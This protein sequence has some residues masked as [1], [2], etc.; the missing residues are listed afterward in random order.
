MQLQIQSPRENTLE[1][2][3]GE[4]V[5]ES[6][7]EASPCSLPELTVQTQIQSALTNLRRLTKIPPTLKVLNN[8]VK[9]ITSSAP[10]RSGTYSDIWPGEWL[11]ETVSRSLMAPTRLLIPL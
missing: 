6:P 4:Q 11:G 1:Q 3:L 7:I 5:V 2:V 9:K 8:Q 10:L